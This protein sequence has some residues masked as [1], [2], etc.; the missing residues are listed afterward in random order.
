VTVFPAIACVASALFSGCGLIGGQT[1]VVNVGYQSK[2]INTINAGTLMRDRGE[3]EKALDKAGAKTGK[4]YRVAWQDFA[5]GAPLTAQ[6]IAAHVDIGSMGD[7]PLLANGSKTRELADA[8]TELVAVTGYNLRGSLNQVVVP[9]DSKANGLAALR[10]KKVSTSLGS[11]ADGMLNVGLNKIGMSSSDVSVVNQD[12]SIG[13]AALEGGQVDAFAQF[14]PWP[15]LTVFRNQGRLVYDGGDNNIP[16]FHGVVVRRAFAD[17]NPEVMQAFM[18]AMAATTTFIQTQPLA[19]ADRVSAI[20]GIEPEVIYLY[21]GPN[22]LVT[23]DMTIKDQLV[24]ALEKNKPFLVAHG[25][26]SADFDVAG[27]V[28]DQYLK[29]ELGDSYQGQRSITHNPS[30]LS[31]NDELCGLPVSD[32]TKASEVWFQGA[33]ETKVSATPT[34]LLRRV[35]ASSTKPRATYVP[36]TVTATRLF[37]DHATWLVDPAAGP[38][39]R[40]KPFATATE[41]IAYQAEHPGTQQISY[42]TAVQ[43]SRTA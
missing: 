10:G 27:F 41:A 40:V 26:V 34:C 35:A 36:D 8:K 37:A 9:P 15:Q 11:A 24:A 23:F 14:V 33:S 6:M 39:E 31:G 12:P 2:T 22:G 21:N 29:A 16:T 13:A 30:A 4:H 7:Y 20:T 1:I 43:Q 42:E 18:D 28:N 5:S 25:A 32:P 3:L 19:A 38:T 17:R